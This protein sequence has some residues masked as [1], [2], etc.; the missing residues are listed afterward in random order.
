MA[1]I[2]DL[3]NT[4]LEIVNE[5]RRKLGVNTIATLTDDKLTTSLIDYLNDVIDYISDFGDW[6]ERREEI[7]VTA[8]SSVFSYLINTSAPLKNISDIYFGDTVA[9]LRYVEIED[10]RRFRRTRGIGQP[11]NWTIN[12]VDNVTTGNPYV[13]VYPMPGANEAGTAFNLLVYTRPAQYTTSSGALVVPFPARMIVAMLLALALFDE[14]RGTQNLDYRQQLSQF[15]E[16]IKETLNR[17]NG[18]SAG[19]PK[20]TPRRGGFR[21]I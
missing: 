5:V 19:D 8:S 2:L 14:S 20:F 18:D 17:Y 1:S 10:M 7:S 13:E 3:R 4:V 16:M 6:Q 11:R 9:P 12:G 15:D 21:R